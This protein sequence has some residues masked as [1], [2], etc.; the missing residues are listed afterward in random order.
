MAVSERQKRAVHRGVWGVKGGWVHWPW[1]VVRPERYFPF[2][3]HWGVD[4]VPEAVTPHQPGKEGPADYQPDA[5]DVAI[6]APMNG[7][8]VRTHDDGQVGGF[9]NDVLIEY[10]VRSLDYPR[11]RVYVLYGH[12]KPNGIIQTN[13]QVGAGDKIAEIGT[14]RL[15]LGEIIHTH[16]QV[17]WDRDDALNYHHP[18]TKNPMDLWRAIRQHVS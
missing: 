10:R 12:L 17:W 16:V 18:T 1:N 8:V 13:H 15:S 6:L 9:F 14:K 3:Q 4:V 11:A 7:V 5:V 2:Q